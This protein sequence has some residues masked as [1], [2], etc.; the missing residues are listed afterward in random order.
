MPARLF[1]ALLLCAAAP[2]Q[3]LPG[4]APLSAPEDAASEIVSGIGRY[5]QRIRPWFAARRDPDPF[6]LR[7]LIG[8]V[9]PRVEPVSMEPVGTTDRSP[10]LAATESFEVFAVRWLALEGVHGEGLYLRQLSAPRH[11]VIFLPGPD[12]LPEQCPEMF[13][14][15][16]AGADVLVPVQ[17]RR[18]AP[19]PPAP[20]GWARRLGEREWIR[21]MGFPLGRHPLGFE[22]QKVVAA[23]DWWKQRHREAP[24]FV[25]GVSDGAWVA[26]FAAIL[27]PR[28][29]LVET[30]DGSIEPA[31]PLQQPLDR[32]VFGLA[33]FFGD[34]DLRGLLRSR[35]AAVPRL[36]ATPVRLAA[37]DP[38]ARA[39]RQ[40]RELEDFLQRLARRSRRVRDELWSSI[41]G[42][43]ADEWRAAAASLERRIREEVIGELPPEPC[44]P[45][46]RTRLA[47]QTPLYRAWDVR[48]NVRPEFPARGV[49]LLPARTEPGVRLPLIVLQHGLQG[50]PQDLYAQSPD[51]RAFATYRNYAETLVR[52]GF[53]VYLPQNPY[54]GDF[55]WL[56]RL[57][58]PL[59][60]TLF[61]FIR[62]QYRAALDWLATL[63]MIDPERIGFYGLSY[64]GKTALRVP[65]FD[66]RF[67]AVVCAGDFNEWIGK[68][69]TTEEPWSYMFTD[70]YDVL[71]WNIAHV[72]SHA[73][74][75]LLIAP[76]PFLVERGH[77]DGVGIDE[78]VMS[79]FARVRR[80]YDEMGIGERAAIAFFNGPHRIDGEEAL[81][82]FRRWLARP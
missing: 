67:R 10:V 35:L 3:P 34:E 19:P 20:G 65:P 54:T 61:S 59:G 33:R 39:A 15:A 57:A 48:L 21:R 36:L 72:A 66:P 1:A 26:Q 44:P 47:A 8:A 68:L 27:D 29:A 37:T 53:A 5:L 56:V 23:V 46:P 2:A 77:R 63:P 52:E 4:T 41:R 42:K 32:I 11:L 69:T 45:E 13:E 78:W 6:R 82:F 49:L 22:V 50:R 24:V 55:R 14:F 80:F 30:L 16:A 58:H 28:I 18:G 70:E 74:L 62:E 31:D 40:V 79:E 60:L 7:R 71:E 81:R 38:E 9:D 12:R 51:S 76:R 73:E 43:D 64:G 17:L 75:A 25:A